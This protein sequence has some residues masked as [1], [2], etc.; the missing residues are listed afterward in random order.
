MQVRKELI[1]RV[2]DDSG[3]SVNYR[4]MDGLLIEDEMTLFMQHYLYKLATNSAPDI[5]TSGA[6]FRKI[7]DYL[8]RLYVDYN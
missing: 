3:N 4:Y 2:V 6:D 7:K 1:D 5:D 8:M